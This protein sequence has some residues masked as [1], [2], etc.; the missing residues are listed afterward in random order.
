MGDVQARLVDDATVIAKDV[1]VYFT[2]APTLPPG[3]AEPTL[4]AL[5]RVEQR[6]RFER[7]IDF[8]APGARG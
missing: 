1:N 2:W 6:S 8:E 5:E 4:D 3:A 7:G